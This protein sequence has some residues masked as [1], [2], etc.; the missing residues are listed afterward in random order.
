MRFSTLRT[1]SVLLA[2][3]LLGTIPSQAQTSFNR[4]WEF[5]SAE[6]NNPTYVGTDN[7][8]RGLAYGRVDDGT[9][10]MVERVFVAT[11]AGDGVNVVV[12]DAADGTVRDSLDTSGIVPSSTGR[13]LTDVG[14][15][16]DGVIVACNEVNNTFITD[17]ETENFRCY[18]WD[19]LTDAPTTVIDYTPPDNT[20]NDAT[21][22]D[23]IGRQFSVAGSASDNTLTLLTA[24]TTPSV[25]VYRFTTSDNG[26]SF[27]A[28]PIERQDRPPSG[29]ING[30]TPVAPGDTAFVTNVINIAP[31]LYAS[32]GSKVA[33]DQGA[34]SSF[35]HTIKHFRVGSRTWFS[36]FRWDTPGQ[37][38]FAQLAEATSGFDQ[39]LPSGTTPN[40]GRNN[41]Q[42][43]FNGTGDL[44]YRVNDDNT[45]TLFV[46]ATNNGIGSYTT[47]TALPVELAAFDA[48]RDGNTVQLTWQ[49]ASET[50]NAG[51]YVQR[52]V[53]GGSFTDLGFREGRGTTTE[54]QTYRFTDRDLPYDATIVQYRLRQVDT[55]GST[56]FSDAVTVELSSPNAVQLFGSAPNPLVEQ[57]E[58][59]YALPQAMDVELAVYDLLGRRVATL[60]SG[61]KQ[62]RRHV[63]Q[64]NASNWTSGT[65]LVRLTA[66]DQV[67]TRRM[68]V[69][70]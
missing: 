63:I 1:V 52:A 36:T 67:L 70:K 5:S 17:S 62:A 40:F 32:D 48:T 47:S 12:L 56:E 43:N 2:L 11:S 20:D 49:T 10:T 16:A 69:I 60:A 42:S 57:G 41:P 3:L 46:L 33:E 19:D 9:G 7:D 25:H 53:D 61:Q 55:D 24:A 38:Q 29:N 59:R 66:G 68:T 28:E 34:F 50:N 23:W 8:A 6:G 21:V 35:T 26:Q 30:V 58:I 4:D 14:V 18:R 54:A 37:D 31:I 15:S 27:S 44:D 13:T 22:G 51:F 45:A 64:V 65:Y 39:L